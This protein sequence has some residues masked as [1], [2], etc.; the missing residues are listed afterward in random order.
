MTK[1]AG[2]HF[3]DSIGTTGIW[4]IPGPVYEI[5]FNTLSA[6]GIKNIFAAGRIISAANGSG[7]EITRVIPVCA[8]TG[9]AAGSA[10]AIMAR[11][12][13]VPIGELQDRLAKDGIVLKIPDKLVEQSEQWLENS[14]KPDIHHVPQP[15]A[16]QDDP[17]D[18]GRAHAFDEGRRQTF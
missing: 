12:G 10:A 16:V 4:N 13:G 14:Y 2:K 1:D 11:T 9:Q 15:G 17:P 6:A 5:P 3:D 18:K 8:L 7:W